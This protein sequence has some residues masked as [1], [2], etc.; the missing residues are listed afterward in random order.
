MAEIDATRQ[1]RGAAGIERASPA[2]SRRNREN[3]S[4][5]TP[6]RACLRNVR[7]RR[8]AERTNRGRCPDMTTITLDLGQTRPD[9]MS[10]RSF[11]GTRRSPAASEAACM[12]DRVGNLIGGETD[13]DG[14]QYRAHH[15]NCEEKASRNRWLSQSITP[16]VSPGLTPNSLEPARQPANSFAQRPVSEP[17]LVAIDDFLIPAACSIGACSR[18]F[19]QQRKSISR[20]GARR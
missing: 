3:R 10:A 20:R 16:T 7:Y 15:R 5:A 17:L 12:V 14:L 19:I 4:P 8:S 6:L 18:C 2:Y 13:V 9:R 1:A 11:R